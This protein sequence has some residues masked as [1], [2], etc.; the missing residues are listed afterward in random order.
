MC[1]YEGIEMRL[2]YIVLFLRCEKQLG[3]KNYMYNALLLTNI[4]ILILC[5][6]DNI[7][8]GVNKIYL[9][10]ILFI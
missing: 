9:K 8:V 7:V 4:F 1:G 5:C 2:V 10:L 3:F 6:N